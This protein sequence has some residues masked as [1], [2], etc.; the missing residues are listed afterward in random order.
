MKFSHEQGWGVG[1]KCPAPSQDLAENLF[2]KCRSRI[3]QT[4]KLF[5]F[6]LHKHFGLRCSCARCGHMVKTWIKGNLKILMASCTRQ[7]TY[8]RN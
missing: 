7:L 1:L 4:V 5:F 2:L 6:I 3:A 8:L